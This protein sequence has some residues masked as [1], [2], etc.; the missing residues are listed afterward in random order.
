MQHFQR[1]AIAIGLGFVTTVLAACGDTTTDSGYP[2]ST[3][4][5]FIESCMGDAG[6]L[7]YAQELCECAIARIQEEYPFEEYREI[8]DRVNAGEALPEE[9]LD[10]TASCYSQISQEKTGSA[11]PQ[12][13]IDNFLE[14]CTAG[15]A[16]RQPVCQ[17]A[18]DRIQEEFSFEEFIRLDRAV[19]EGGQP[20][21]EITT[22]MEACVRAPQ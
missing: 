10:I 6:E 21:A 18:I 1:R 12:Q 11:Y 20:P 19:G 7:E 14:S 22:I 4:D 3:I 2:Q 15:D 9:M 17:C 13:A 16:S 8:S 5:G